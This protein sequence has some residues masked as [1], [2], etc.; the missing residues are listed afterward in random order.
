MRKR[1]FGSKKLIY[2]LDHNTAE[3]Y[4]E[5]NIREV[6]ADAGLYGI[7]SGGNITPHPSD[8]YRIVLDA[9]I[10]RTSTGER[11]VISSS[12]DI[13]ILP[14]YDPGFG[15]EVW[16]TSYV[17]YAYALAEPD[18]DGDDIAYYKDYQNSYSFHRVQGEVA[19]AG[20]AVR[21]TVPAEAVLLCDILYDKDLYDTGLIQQSDI[22]ITR[23]DEGGLDE[24]VR[25]D[26]DS[27]TGPL[28]VHDTVSAESLVIEWAT[29]T[30][31]S[32]NDIVS[33]GLALY[34]C[35]SAH[36]SST[37]SADTSHWSSASGLGGIE[38]FTVT[39]TGKTIFTLTT[40]TPAAQTDILVTI[41]G[42]IQHQDAFTLSG[43][44]IIFT[45]A[46]IIGNTVQVL[47][48]R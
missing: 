40:F 30:G 29:L 21:P 17:K 47:R 3:A 37:F 42:V 23:R 46:L 45:E 39:S 26:G 44:N 38:T 13:T 41:C 10:A 18:V 11:I 25:K 4:T 5:L 9:L 28:T 2:A 1:Q 7:I 6:V 27:M 15:N 12:E 43:S 19:A 22:D 24:Y 35:I 20:Y 16:L 32:I 34:K 48:L 8:P 31:Y 14:Y 36:T 33:Y